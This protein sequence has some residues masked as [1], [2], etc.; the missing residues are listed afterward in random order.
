MVQGEGRTLA[1]GSGL[2]GLNPGL[3]IGLLGDKARS[4][5]SGPLSLAAAGDLPSF[6]GKGL[7]QRT[8]SAQGP[9][10]LSGNWQGSNLWSLTSSCQMLLAHSLGGGRRNSAF[11][12][13]PFS[14]SLLVVIIQRRMDREA[15]HW[16]SHQLQK[17]G[18]SELEA[19]TQAKA[20]CS[21][22]RQ[23]PPDQGKCAGLPPV[24]PLV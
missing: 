18:G 7:I 6:E 9:G 17:T 4:P 10:W 21:I 13:S 1:L 2:I 11:T 20:V 24:Y 14:F 8:L 19:Y 12:Q 15:T 22:N 16:R 5:L 23:M 3:T